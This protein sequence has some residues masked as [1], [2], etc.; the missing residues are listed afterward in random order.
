MKSKKVIQV[1]I[2]P[3]KSLKLV[4]ALC[5]STGRNLYLVFLVAALLSKKIKYKLRRLA[6]RYALN[7]R[8]NLCVI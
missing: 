6:Q 8:E 1:K 4:P 7:I 5:A 3:N 2:K